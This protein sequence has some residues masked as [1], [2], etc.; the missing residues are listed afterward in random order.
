MQPYQSR[1]IA[2]TT[3]DPWGRGHALMHEKGVNRPGRE[4]EARA[5]CESMADE[6]PDDRGMWLAEAWWYAHGAT[7]PIPWSTPMMRGERVGVGRMREP[8]EEAGC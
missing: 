5:F 4:A 6:Y 2:P 1:T 7:G 3:P 8:G